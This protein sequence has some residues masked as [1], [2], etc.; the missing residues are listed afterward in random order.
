MESDLK[1]QANAK[2]FIDDEEIKR[3]ITKIVSL[4]LKFNI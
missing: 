4:F 2:L 1:Q 3:V